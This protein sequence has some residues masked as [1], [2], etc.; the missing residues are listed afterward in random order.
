[1]KSN[2]K[3]KQIAVDLFDGKIFCDRHIPEGEQYMLAS[4]FMPIALSGLPDISDEK[5]RDMAFLFE[6]NS[7]AMPRSINGYPIF[8]SVQYLNKKEAEQMFKFY[9]EYKTLKEEFQ[10]T[11][12]ANTHKNISRVK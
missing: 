6:Y 1:M 3:L 10:G 12:M 7:Q 11:N 4:I 9:E 2:E 5:I 8:G